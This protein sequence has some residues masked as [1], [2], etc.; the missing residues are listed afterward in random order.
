[1]KTNPESHRWI[2]VYARVSTEQQHREGQS[3]EGQIKSM[4]AV[5]ELRFPGREVR[6]FQDVESGRTGNRPGLRVLGRH[7]DGRD[8][9]AVVVQSVDRLWRSLRDGLDWIERLDTAK[10]ALLIWSEF[11][12]T[13]SAIG[14]A[15]LQIQLT[16]AELE[17]NKIGDRVRLAHQRTAN[18]GVK[19]PGLR[20]YGWR[21][22]E[23]RKLERDEEEQRI[24]DFVLGERKLARS[25]A[26]CAQ[27]LN[28]IGSRTVMG[29]TWTH[30]GLA[31]VIEAA[32]RRRA[33][34]AER[35]AQVQPPKPL[36]A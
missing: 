32:E 9:H 31:N 2:A 1:M 30:G 11:V 13:E 10:T 22:G 24:V 5:A 12:D 33:A 25:W 18:A 23:G 27:A 35:A 26:S 21:V 16:M 36:L 20:P 19:G 17:S 6:V 34:E 8:V 3:L 4:K 14:R 29:R 15:W 7:I 28:R